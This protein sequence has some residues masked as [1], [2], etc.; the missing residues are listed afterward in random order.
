MA[1]VVRQLLRGGGGAR[2]VARRGSK[3]SAAPEAVQL[4]RGGPHC[5]CHHPR[6]LLLRR[7]GADFRSACIPYG[8]IRAPSKDPKRS[9]QRRGRGGGGDERRHP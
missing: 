9:R 8:C 6:Q 7:G 5:R 1:A 4:R 3:A 2:L